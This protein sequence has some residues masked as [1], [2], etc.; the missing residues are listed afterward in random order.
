VHANQYYP[1]D[2]SFFKSSLDS[3]LLALLW[4]KYWIRYGWRCRLWAWG[5]GS[6]CPFMIAAVRMMYVKGLAPALGA[7]MPCGSFSLPSK[8]SVHS[9]YPLAPKHLLLCLSLCCPYP[10]LTE[11]CPNSTLSSSPLI[12]NREYTIKSIKDLSDKLDQAENQLTH[13]NR[14]AHAHA[15]LHSHI[16][17]CTGNCAQ[18]A[19]TRALLSSL[20]RKA[21]KTSASLHRAL[22]GF[23]K[24]CK[25]S[26]CK[27]SARI[28]SLAQEM[29]GLR[30]AC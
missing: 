14:R 3:H 29:L 18:G 24:A 22:Q 15:C 5:S 30:K 6:V 11:I 8:S 19:V 25:D 27:D 9:S 16:R 23:L 20:S 2:V 12:A 28:A 4:N 10:S 26:A 1:L 21:R 7:A 13:N 17:R